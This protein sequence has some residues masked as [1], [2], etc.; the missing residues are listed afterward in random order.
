[1]EADDLNL[2]SSLRSPSDSLRRESGKEKQQQRMK[3]PKLDDDGSSRGWAAG[4]IESKRQEKEK[5][6]TRK[7]RYTSRMDGRGYQA[8]MALG[9]W[10]YFLYLYPLFFSVERHFEIYTFSSPV[11]FSARREKMCTRRW[12]P[13]HHHVLFNDFLHH[14]VSGKKVYSLQGAQF[15]PANS[16]EPQEVTTVHVSTDERM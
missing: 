13:P 16:H 7:T 15:D 9:F 8:S 3:K 2:Q 5:H 4:R 10:G 11:V 12:Y 1:M 6:K 14:R